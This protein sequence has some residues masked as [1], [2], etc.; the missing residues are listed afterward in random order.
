MADEITID[1]FRELVAYLKRHPR[2]RFSC[3]THPLHP[4][5]NGPRTFDRFERGQLRFKTADGSETSLPVRWEAS[6]HE[7][8]IEFFAGGFRFTQFN[9][10]CTVRFLED[11]RS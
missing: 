2:V 7:T 1:C 9:V 11:P 8:G 6:P 5:L 10:T 4:S 3:E